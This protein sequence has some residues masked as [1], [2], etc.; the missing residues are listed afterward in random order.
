MIIYVSLIVCV[1][2]KTPRQLFSYLVF[3]RRVRAEKFQL[4]NRSRDHLT[5][6][7]LN[8]VLYT[9]KMSINF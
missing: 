1:L 5:Y 7:I 6:S 4:I 9:G 3:I 2:N 8:T